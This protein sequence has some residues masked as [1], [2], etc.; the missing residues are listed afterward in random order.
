MSL[1]EPTMKKQ[2]WRLSGKANSICKIPG[3]RAEP[4]WSG[5]EKGSQKE[6]SHRS[7]EGRKR[8]LET[9]MGRVARLWFHLPSPAYLPLLSFLAALS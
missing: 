1:R 5:R 4:A 7:G 9:P 3:G 2:E 6:Q 8:S